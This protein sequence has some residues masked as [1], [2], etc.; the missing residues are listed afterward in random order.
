MK[1][2]H[3]GDVLSV[4]TPYLLSPKHIGG[5]YE[6]LNFLTGDSLYTHQ[7]GRACEEVE[8]W[9]RTQFP[10]LMADEPT[11]AQMLAVFQDTLEAAPT[12][13]YKEH[14]CTDFVEQVRER[15]GLPVM[16]PVYEMGEDMHLHIDPVEELKSMVGDDQVLVVDLSK[17]EDDES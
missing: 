16:L 8:P 14:I 15:F 9:L 11:M 2:F 4:T 6:I 3:I 17:G 7:L 5:V 13:A 12:A 1:Q 10:Q